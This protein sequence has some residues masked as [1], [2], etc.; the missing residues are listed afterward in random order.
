V[1]DSSEVKKKKRGQYH[2]GDLRT[3]LLRATVELVGESGVEAFTLREAA[4]RAGVS[5]AAPYRHFPDRAALLGAVA[6]EGF[7][8]LLPQLRKKLEEKAGNDLGAIAALGASFVAFGS[9]HPSHFRLMYG[10]HLPE[11]A[12]HPRLDELDQEGFGMLVQAISRAQEGGA[13]QGGDP[14]EIAVV[15]FS[16][17][18]GAVSLYLDGEMDRI[19][20]SADEAR[21]AI[22]SASLYM[23]Q[24]LANQQPRTDV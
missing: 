8:I 2:H 24:G 13:I 14:R 10:P 7:G 11:R 21:R 3:A 23:L 16:L 4:K 20:F 22:D 1:T 12:A 18:Y 5:S 6:E 9:S 19:G 15:A 17:V